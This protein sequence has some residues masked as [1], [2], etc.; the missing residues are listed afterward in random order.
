MRIRNFM[1]GFCVFYASAFAAISVISANGSEENDL[2]LYCKIIHG[3]ERIGFQIHGNRFYALS[4]NNKVLI[5]NKSEEIFQKWL[6]EFASK[7]GLV[8]VTEESR[9]EWGE[10][11]SVAI[12]KEGEFNF[13]VV[14]AESEAFRS[15]T[16]MKNQII[17]VLANNSNVP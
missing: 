15:L 10:K 7:D 13:F 11:L 3:D 17:L 8:I 6:S 5:H 1:F 16:E 12:Y 2:L 4:N 14:E 9:G